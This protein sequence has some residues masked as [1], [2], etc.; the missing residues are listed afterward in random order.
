MKELYIENDFGLFI[1][2]LNDNKPHK[3][4]AIQLS[5]SSNEKFIITNEKGDISSYQNC[6][7]NSNVEHQFY[8]EGISL[9]VLINPFSSFGHTITRK[10]RDEKIISIKEKSMQNIQEDFQKLLNQTIVLSDFYKN[11]KQNLEGFKC[12]CELDNHIE[13]DRIFHAIKYIETHRGEVISVSEISKVCSLSESRFL[14]LFK[15]NT[16]MHYRRYQLWNKLIKSLPYLKSQSITE[17]AHMFG[18]ADSSHY[19]RTFKE[20][21]GFT[22]K[23]I[24]NL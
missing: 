7:I 21:F 4:Y 24:L 3:H 17:T 14:H 11:T 8:S 20:T 9:I 16:G 19:S 12:T 13:D 2:E 23:F 22:P 15:E 1:G 5:F 18:F 6:L 10:Y